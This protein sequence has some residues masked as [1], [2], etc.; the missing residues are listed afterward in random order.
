MNRLL[1]ISFPYFWTEFVS[2]LPRFILTIALSIPC[3][4]TYQSHWHVHDFY[5]GTA[6]I[7]EDHLN[8]I[9]SK[10]FLDHVHWSH[11]GL[12]VDW[13]S[14]SIHWIDILINTWSK[15][16]YSVNTPSTLDQQPTHLHRSKIF[17]MLIDSSSSLNHFPPFKRVGKSLYWY[18]LPVLGYHR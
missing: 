4:Y 12:S 6:R 3:P 11:L 15:S 2:L 5:A 16:R 10:D 14:W 8:I 17:S 1:R 13:Y 9:E 18:S 7:F